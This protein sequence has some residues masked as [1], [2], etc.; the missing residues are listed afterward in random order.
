MSY[1]VVLDDNG[2]NNTSLCAFDMAVLPLVEECCPHIEEVNYPTDTKHQIFY[3][4][5]VRTLDVQRIQIQPLSKNTI[6]AR[7]GDRS[8]CPLLDGCQA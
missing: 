1:I 6:H 4:V 7:S 3:F 2:R 8:E 5:G